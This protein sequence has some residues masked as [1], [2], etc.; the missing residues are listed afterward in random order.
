MK[1]P[2]L[3]VSIPLIFIGWCVA[4]YQVFGKVIF[5]YPAMWAVVGA[6]FYGLHVV[7]RGSSDSA[8]TASADKSSTGS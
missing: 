3:K 6:F 8:A 7:T 5:A 1:L 4:G 2:S